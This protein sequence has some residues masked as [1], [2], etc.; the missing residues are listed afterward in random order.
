MAVEA[1]CTSFEPTELNKEFDA[2]LGSTFDA[3]ES[4][5][6]ASRGEVKIAPDAPTDSANPKTAAET[7][8]PQV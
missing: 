3:D 2:S 4:A 1:V 8:G 6:K 7:R 5:A